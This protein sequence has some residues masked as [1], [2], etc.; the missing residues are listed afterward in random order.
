MIR[1]VHVGSRN[2]KT[3]PD[4][5]QHRLN[6]EFYALFEGSL[7]L[8]LEDSPKNAPEAVD[9]ANF[10]VFPPMTRWMWEG[11]GE[12]VERAALQFTRVPTLL[13][14]TVRPQ[15]FLEK[16]L[17]RDDLRRVRA[18][19]EELEPHYKA[20]D[21]FSSIIGERAMLELA[22]IA[23]KDVAPKPLGLRFSDQLWHRYDEAIFYY[24][25]QMAERPSVEM[26]AAHLHISANQLRR[27]FQ[28]IAQA[29]G[30]G[31]GDGTPKRIFMRLRMERAAEIL[32]NT[33][34]TLDEV[35]AQCG[36]R[37]LA[38]FGRAFKRY[39]GSTPNVWRRYIAMPG[40]D[41][42]QKLQLSTRARPGLQRTPNEP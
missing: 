9:G 15:I 18:I 26:I 21:Q 40:Q 4:R 29:Q 17:G 24:R 27:D 19:A 22:L 39:Y 31:E 41:R 37:D 11:D 3:F 10:W 33:A 23:L 34:L 16:K 25:Q 12:P 14:E 13:E 20:P 30:L 38:D 42:W 6:W 35:A 36:F 28:D 32:M 8:M 5:F 1:L 2:F 7:T